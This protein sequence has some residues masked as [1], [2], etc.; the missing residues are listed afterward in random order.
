MCRHCGK[1]NHWIKKC[2]IGFKN[3]ET[4]IIDAT[5]NK[6]LRDA[7]FNSHD[8]I[9][10]L[11]TAHLMQPAS[12]LNRAKNR[13]KFGWSTRVQCIPWCIRSQL[14]ATCYRSIRWK[15]TLP[16]MSS[17]KQPDVAIS[18]GRWRRFAGHTI[19]F[20]L[21]L[22][23]P[24]LRRNLLLVAQFARVVDPITFNSLKCVAD[25]KGSNLTIDKRIDKKF[26]SARHDS[27]NQQ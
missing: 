20:S 14:W 18:R 25:V 5:V 3:S 11:F 17:L 26:A 7:L 13:R 1:Y 16:T 6:T 24:K 8:D 15:L 23:V 22:F 9:D 10:Y 12:S 21:I 4:A 19:M 27:N 2:P